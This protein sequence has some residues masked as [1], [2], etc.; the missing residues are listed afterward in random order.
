[1]IYPAVLQA[2]GESQSQLHFIQKQHVHSGHLAN[3]TADPASRAV[4]AVSTA[5][6]LL[7]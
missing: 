1:M 7:P 4:T 3:N 5:A 6:E 2:A